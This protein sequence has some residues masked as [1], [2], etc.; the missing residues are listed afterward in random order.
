[1]RSRLVGQNRVDPCAQRGAMLEASDPADDGQ[2]SL[3]N[4]L[5]S[6][7]IGINV[8]ARDALH[9]RVVTLDERMKRALVARAQGIYEP[10]LAFGGLGGRPTR[11]C[12]RGCHLRYTPRAT[13]AR[14]APWCR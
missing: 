10:L 7:G 9:H 3:L 5:L 11:G 8:G 12:E 1:M 4:D 6:Q 13:S 14:C 2:P